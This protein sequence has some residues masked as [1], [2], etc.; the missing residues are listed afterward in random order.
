MLIF[1]FHQRQQSSLPR[2][3]G[4]FPPVQGAAAINTCPTHASRNS[5]NSMVKYT[6]GWD[7]YVRRT[8][9]LRPISQH[10]RGSQRHY[11]RLFSAQ[12]HSAEEKSVK[13]GQSEKNNNGN[14]K[15]I[16]QIHCFILQAKCF[17]PSQE[18]VWNVCVREDVFTFDGAGFC[19][20]SHFLATIS[21]RMKWY[22]RRN[23]PKISIL[24]WRAKKKKI[25]SIYFLLCWKM[26]IL[27]ASDDKP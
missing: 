19:Q 2:C 7:A 21:I 15:R 16:D 25:V 4:F 3:S 17:F 10:E 14:A 22:R 5:R 9:A 24:L 27:S 13:K 1:C 26:V 8:R 12:S 11:C 20:V 18:L 23:L 6:F